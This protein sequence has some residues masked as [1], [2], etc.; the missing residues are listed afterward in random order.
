MSIN[1]ISNNFGSDK[2]LWTFT[3]KPNFLKKYRMLQI[4]LPPSSQSK[5]HKTEVFRR[6][7]PHS[8]PIRICYL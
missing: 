4:T 3:P 2:I 7:I 8:P 1:Q 6:E 5:Y